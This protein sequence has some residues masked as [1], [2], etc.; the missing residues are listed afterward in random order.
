MR[1]GRNLLEPTSQREMVCFRATPAHQ[2]FGIEKCLSINSSADKRQTFNNGVPQ[3]G[4]HNCCGLHQS[5]GRDT[6]TPTTSTCPAVVELVRPERHSSSRTSRPRKIEHPRGPGVSSICGQQRLD[7][8]SQ[9]HQALIERL[10]NGPLC[11]EAYTSTSVLCH[12]EAGSPRFPLRCIQSQL[13][14]TQG[15][16]FS[17]VQLDTKG[18]GQNNIRSGRSFVSSARVASPTVVASTTPTTDTATNPLTSVTT[19]AN[20]PSGTSSDPPN[21]PS[22]TLGRI[23]YLL[24]RYQAEG[25]PTNVAELLIAAIRPSTHK[26]YESNWK[27]WRSWFCARKVNPISASLK[28]LLTFLTECFDSGL[29]YRSINVIR[30]TLSGTH[31][32]IDG[33]LVGQHPYVVSLLKGI[34]N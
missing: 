25:L 24:Q 10:Q 5:P 8:R 6:F 12:L 18:P 3:H 34:L 2:L 13:A 28:D 19:L 30:S 9:P 7:V 22:P 27:R 33:H 26:T 23:P 11:L 15:L 1:V 16:R 20:R 31:P 17:P 32:K 21:V 4:Q 14:G 29:Q